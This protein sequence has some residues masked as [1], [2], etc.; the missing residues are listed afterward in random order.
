MSYYK[1]RSFHLDKSGNPQ[2]TLADSSVYPYSYFKTSISDGIPDENVEHFCVD[3]LEGNIHP[4]NTQAMMNNPK[5]PGH[6]LDVMRGLIKI[7]ASAV[8]F[9]RDLELKLDTTNR[10]YHILAKGYGVPMLK[11]E[12]INIE[13]LTNELKTFNEQAKQEYKDKMQE[14]KD[15]GIITTRAAAM[16]DVFPGYDI[17]V[18]ANA[19]ECIVARQENYNNGG[20]LDN[21]DGKALFLG[22]TS[23]RLFHS[24]S[25]GG[26][27]FTKERLFMVRDELIK[28][29][30]EPVMTKVEPDIL[31]DIME[32]RKPEGL[33]F[34][35]QNNRWIAVD[36]SHGNLY[37]EEFADKKDALSF[38]SGDN[39]FMEPKFEIYQLKEDE[40]LRD[41]HFA[42]YEE[43]SKRGLSVQ[44]AIMKSCMPG[45]I[46]RAHLIS[47]MKNLISTDRIFSRQRYICWPLILSWFHRRKCSLR[48]F[49]QVREVWCQPVTLSVLSTVKDAWI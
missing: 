46:R 30:S 20:M 17:L 12:T 5:K 49:P 44:E 15:K 26:P 33:L 11:G 35:E 18:N 13:K 9:N 28:S 39:N 24:L 38:L 16:S 8:D 34:S 41:Y 2:M 14:Y 23:A 42:G 32:T 37:T 1:L 6:V 47:C 48:K 29:S 10:L 4:N 7:H 25:H 27:G 40:D 36:N 31:Y 43:L 19:D 45:I 22:N 21:S 3:L